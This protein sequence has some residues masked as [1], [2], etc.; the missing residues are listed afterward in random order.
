LE[1]C[2]EGRDARW[3]HAGEEATLISF[4]GLCR[5]PSWRMRR[6]EASGSGELSVPAID[7]ISAETN[8]AGSLVVTYNEFVG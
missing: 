1:C 8:I 5:R 7:I 6:H 3:Y 4:V 2:A